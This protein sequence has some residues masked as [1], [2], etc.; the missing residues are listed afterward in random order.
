ML[1]SA[2]GDS[3]SIEGEERIDHAVGFCQPKL[4]QDVSI[5]LLTGSPANWMGDG[6]HRCL[7]PSHGQHGC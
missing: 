2:S 5:W 7:L 1:V 3:Q 4:R 6:N